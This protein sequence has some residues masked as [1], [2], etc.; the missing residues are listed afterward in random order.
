M[1]IMPV[2][3][4]CRLCGLRNHGVGANQCQ[5]SLTKFRLQSPFLPFFLIVYRGCPEKNLTASFSND[6]RI[7]SR[8][9]AWPTL[10]SVLWPCFTHVTLLGWQFPFSKM[11]F[12]P[13]HQANCLIFQDVTLIPPSIQSLP[14]GIMSNLFST[15]LKP[16]RCLS[17]Y[18]ISV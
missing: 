12:F 6:Y 7:N 9:L 2:F 13:V 15:S 5:A 3:S 8:S 10:F 14:L 1:Q 16:N 18:C 17:F 4:L 11:T